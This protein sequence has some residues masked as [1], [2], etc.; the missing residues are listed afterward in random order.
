MTSRPFQS[1]R[2][3]RITSSLSGRTVGRRPDKAAT[4]ASSSRSRTTAV[5]HGATQEARAPDLEVLA[6]RRT[7]NRRPRSRMRVRRRSAFTGRTP[8]PEPTVREPTVTASRRSCRDLGPY[9]PVSD[10]Q[11]LLSPQWNPSQ[12]GFLG[13]Y[14]SIAASTSAGSN[15][16][17]PIWADTRNTSA[18]PADRPTRSPTKTC[19]SRPSPYRS[20]LALRGLPLP[21]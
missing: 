8:T 15:T 17:Y 12:A 13:D 1:I 4:T 18:N 6:A 2:T 10:S 5:R 11:A 9:T 20:R 21:A 3:T 7:S 19:S 16:V 14:S